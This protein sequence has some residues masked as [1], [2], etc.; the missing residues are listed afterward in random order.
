[1]LDSKTDGVKKNYW[2]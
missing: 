2:I 1:M